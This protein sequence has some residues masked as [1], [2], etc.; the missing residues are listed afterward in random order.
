MTTIYIIMKR[1]LCGCGG[2]DELVRT[3]DPC[4]EMPDKVLDDLEEEADDW[5]YYYMI[6]V[7]L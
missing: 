6:K 5:D 4:E 3:I 7:P 1:D 2:P